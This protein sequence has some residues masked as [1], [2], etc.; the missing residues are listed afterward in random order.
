MNS[1]QGRGAYRAFRSI[2]TAVAA[3]Q[4]RSPRVSR[5]F[6]HKSGVQFTLN[7]THPIVP[8]LCDEQ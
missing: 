3:V 5:F 1:K 7:N 2:V 4:A 8:G 6:Q